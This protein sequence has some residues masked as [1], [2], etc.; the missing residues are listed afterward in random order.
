M[1]LQGSRTKA[2]G[3]SVFVISTKRRYRRQIN[4]SVS[5]SVISTPSKSTVGTIQRIYGISKD[6]FAAAT[7]G[8][9]P[10]PSDMA[11]LSGFLDSL[12][13]HDIGLNATMPHFIASPHGNPKVT[14]LPIA[15][16][17]TLSMGVFCF[18]QSAMIPLHDHPGMTVFSKILLGSMHIK[19]YDWVIAPSASNQISRMPNGARLAK[20]H[21]D[22]IF[23]ATSKTVVLYPENGGNLHCFNAM[24][25]CAVLDVMG[26]PYSLEEGRDCSYFSSKVASA[27]AGGDG[28]YAWLNEVPCSIEMK[29]AH[30]Y[31]HAPEHSVVSS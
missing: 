21:T 31:A 26:P 19:S 7:P 23:D 13:L 10:L 3:K 1:P 18:P 5:S 4:P 2:A 29:V 15:D 14:Y 8:F 28:Q 30:I 27:G 9:V 16:T 25:P 12:M 22:A 11:R 24:S 17:P 20:L 6:V